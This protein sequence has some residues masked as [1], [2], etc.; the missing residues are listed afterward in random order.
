MIIV[1]SP[2]VKRQDLDKVLAEVK[3]TGLSPHVSVGK[4]RKLVMVI[5]DE[6][7]LN[8]EIVK[9]LPGVEDVHPILKPYKQASREFHPDDTVIKVDNVSIGGPEVIVMAGPCAIESEKQIIEIAHLVKERGGHI[10]RGGAFKPRTSPYAFQGLG[11][12]GLKY[13]KKA[14]E[15]TGLVTIS[16]VMDTAEVALVAKYVDILQI[17]TRN[18]QNFKLLKAVG[19]TRKPV[20][21]KR[22]MSSYFDEFLMS[23]EYI[24]SEGNYNVILCERGIR[25]FVEYTRN[26]LDL[27]II[28]MLKAMTHLPV[29]VD[30]SHGTGVRKIVRP[31]SRAAIAAGADGI[32]V[33]THTNPEK[34]VS[35][36]AQTVDLEEFGRI[37]TESKAIAR[38]IG[39]Y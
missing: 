33:E 35:D 23:A 10:L 20:L 14:K 17:G 4:E 36:A 2:N 11:E 21:L 12:K 3:K 9:A 30:A 24:M 28:P 31:M 19:K 5:G 13:L 26:T 25:T 18:M 37:V 7:K 38:V 6:R 32:V 16:E 8:I 34:S 22:G 39:R 1:M 29:V 15:E 27:N